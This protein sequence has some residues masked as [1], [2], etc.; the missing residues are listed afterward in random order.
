MASGG[1]R[2]P[3]HR[4]PSVVPAMRPSR[5][6]GGGGQLYRERER[7]SV[8]PL[9][10]GL[11]SLALGLVAAVVITSTAPSSVMAWGIVGYVAAGFLP[12]LFLGWDSTAQRRGLKNPNFRPRRDYS[13]FLRF[14]VFVGIAVAI[15]HIWTVADVLA[16]AVSELLYVWEVLSP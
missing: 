1:D 9:V 5:R 7:A 2:A 12:P 6:S 3:G 4:S 11:I 8:L 14:I 16:V 15:F 10:V 13:R